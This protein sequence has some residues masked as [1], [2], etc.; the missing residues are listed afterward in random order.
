MNIPAAQEEEEE[1]R[2]RQRAALWTLRCEYTR[3]CSGASATN[4]ASGS[5]A[6]YDA[7]NHVSE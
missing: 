1:E 2:F 6:Q 7:Q 4:N 3:R 5:D